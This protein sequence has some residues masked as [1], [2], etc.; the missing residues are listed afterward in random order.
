MTRETVFDLASLT[1][2]LATTLAVLHLIQEK[3]L[4]LSRTL[5]D[6]LPPFTGTEKEAITIRQLLSHTSGYPDYRPFY[7]SLRTMPPDT[8]VPALRDLLVNEPPAYAPGQ[9]TVYSDLGFMVLRWVVEILTGQ[10]LDRFLTE[11]IYSPLGLEDLF[12]I[13]LDAPLAINRPFAATEQC[14]WRKRLIQGAVH[15]D[16]AFAVGGIEGHAGLFGTARAVFRLL[17]DLLS[18]YRQDPGPHRFDPLQLERFFSRQPDSDRAL[19]FDM[20]A[21]SDSSS[22][23]LFSAR[24]V[25]HLGFTGTSFWMD[26]DRSI[27]IILLTNRIHPS[28]ANEKIKRFRPI[29]HDMI[30]KRL[31]TVKDS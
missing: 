10:R 27:I 15:D 11:K 16:N 6:V 7:T 24:T 1:K 8:R 28:R 31:L 3:Q 13:D 20:P 23:R 2:P 5:A 29:I 14:P 21:V 4:A 12:F 25:G 18:A 19:G 9:R 26:L 30:M 22:G 17:S